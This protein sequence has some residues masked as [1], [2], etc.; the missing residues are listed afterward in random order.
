MKITEK[1]INTAKSYIETVKK[2]RDETIA[3]KKTYQKKRTQL[4][5]TLMKLRSYAKR[6][7]VRKISQYEYEIIDNKE[8]NYET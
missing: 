6:G 8:N 7:I 2:E 4:E 1:S 5:K 3:A